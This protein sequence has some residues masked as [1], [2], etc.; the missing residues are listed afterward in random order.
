MITKTKGPGH[1]APTPGKPRGARIKRNSQ[2]ETE[3][4][5]T[6]QT[7]EC[8]TPFLAEAPGLCA[9]CAGPDGQPP[10][11]ERLLSVKTCDECGQ[12]YGAELEE[13]PICEGER[14]LREE[15]QPAKNGRSGSAKSSAAADSAE[16]TS[17]PRPKKNGRGAPKSSAGG[18]SPPSAPDSLP[19]A[20]LEL[21]EVVAPIAKIEVRRQARTEFDEAK[22]AALAGE[23][24]ADGML[25]PPL[26]RHHPEAKTGKWHYVLVD[27]ERRIRA[28]KQLG[29]TSIKVQLVSGAMDDRRAK[30]IQGKANIDRESFNDVDLAR[31]CQWATSPESEGGGGLTQVALAKQLGVTQ[32]EISNRIRLL[33]VPDWALELN[34]SGQM[35][36]KHCLELLRYEGAAPILAECKKATLAWLEEH[37]GLPTA[38]DYAAEILDDVA[39]ERTGALNGSHYD[40]RCGNIK[41]AVE[42][43]DAER[44]ALGIVQVPERY[45]DELEPRALNK[46]LA[47]KLL[48]TAKA[49]AI[50]AA[51]AKQAK[52]ERGAKLGRGKEKAELTPA[53]RKARAAEQAKQHENRLTAWFHDWLRVLCAAWLKSG[54]TS[55]G[56]DAARLVM[57]AL[58]ERPVDGQEVYDLFFGGAFPDRTRKVSSHSRESTLELLCGM[59]INQALDAEL[60]LAVGLLLNENGEPRGDTWRP[61]VPAETLHTMARAMELDLAA[62]WRDDRKSEM[63]ER[64]WELHSKD[65]LLALGK[66]LGVPLLET[67]K[68]SAMIANLIGQQKPLPLP[69]SLAG[70]VQAASG[71]KKGNRKKGGGSK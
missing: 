44:E 63:R 48:A 4:G 57:W 19:S 62:A 15:R 65:Q 50:D 5:Y 37:G 32:A 31:W 7:C 39:R 58:I 61:P 28:A 26:V 70:L 67:Q 55:G 45:G 60:S 71:A 49:A 68:K 38:D 52:K 34:I 30:L 12:I 6:W 33:R 51:E 17:A 23:I 18:G 10:A 22:L 64:F 41:F 13:C 36:R 11:A 42:A 16:Q 54:D 43:T 20:P 59:T 3:T 53:Q 27:G 40:H 21:I 14:L 24:A 8:G 56:F 66:E 47:A 1:F 35:S 69:K 29:W 9:V 46:K 2:A 25:Q